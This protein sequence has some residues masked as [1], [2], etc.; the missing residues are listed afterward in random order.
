MG[1]G[2]GGGHRS[3]GRRPLRP[4]GRRLRAEARRRRLYVPG[5]GR[6]AA[7]LHRRSLDHRL[8]NGL[9]RLPQSRR[10]LLRESGRHIP[11]RRRA[12][13]RR[14]TRRRILGDVGSSP[15]RL[16]SALLPPGRAA[17][18]GYVRSLVLSARARQ[19]RG[20]LE[21]RALSGRRARRLARSL[22]RLLEYRDRRNAVPLPVRCACRGR[23]HAGDAAAGP[24]RVVVPRR[25]SARSGEGR[26]GRDRALP[27]WNAAP[28]LD[29]AGHRR[30]RLGPVVRRRP[31]GGADPA[32]LHESTWTT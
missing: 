18:G 24:H 13:S 19:E 25:G 30:Q 1:W 14:T 7:H 3:R 26:D 12:R 8:R 4:P 5:A 22:G 2:D 21:P 31:H 27:R 11:D 23:P 29:G 10:D 15:R 16:T 17:R 20:Q 6:R 28:R 32:R 9:L